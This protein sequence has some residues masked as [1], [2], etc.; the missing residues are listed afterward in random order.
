MD[1][2][3]GD[4]YLQ[5]T[6]YSFLATEDDEGSSVGSGTQKTDTFGDR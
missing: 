3:S 5:E 6:M 4:S 1:H 2:F